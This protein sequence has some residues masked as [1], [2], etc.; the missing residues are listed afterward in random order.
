MNELEYYNLEEF[1]KYQ[2]L[3]QEEYLTTDEYKFVVGYDKLQ[4]DNFFYIGDYSQYG[5]Y[6]NLNTY[7]EHD[8]EKRQFEMEVG[9]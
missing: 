9:I 3:L 4:E 5:D 6:L 2:N 7:S 1:N 8:H